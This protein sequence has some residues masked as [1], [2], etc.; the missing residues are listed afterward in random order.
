[1]KHI[2]DFFAENNLRFK[3]ELHTLPEFTNARMQVVDVSG[4]PVTLY[5]RKGSLDSYYVKKISTIRKFSLVSLEE[6]I[7][8]FM[9]EVFLHTTQGSDDT[10]AIY[11]PFGDTEIPTLDINIFSRI[12][13]KTLMSTSGC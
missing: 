12:D 2:V 9:S 4:L 3:L 11:S 6:A 5:F 8:V 7:S 1:M 10:P 13:I